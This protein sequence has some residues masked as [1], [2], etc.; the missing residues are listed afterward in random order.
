MQITPLDIEKGLELYKRGVRNNVVPKM[1]L[2]ASVGRK[3]WREAVAVLREW[4]NN[5]VMKKYEYSN[6]QEGESFS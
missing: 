4:Y 6:I 2:K 3:K 5:H 1:K